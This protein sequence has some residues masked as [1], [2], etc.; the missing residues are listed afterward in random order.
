L[1]FRKVLTFDVGIT[2]HNSVFSK[3]CYQ[4]INYKMKVFNFYAGPAILPQEVIK[5]TADEIINFS[6][7]GLSLMEI[8]HRSK[9]FI[10][11][12][13]E[14]VY[15]VKELLQLSEDYEV[16]F[17]S[18]GASSQ[19][20]M[21]PMNLLDENGTAAYLDTGTWASKAIQEARLF[22]NV[23][24]VASSKDQKYSFIPKDYS[25]NKDYTYFHITSN[26]TIYGTQMHH[27]PDTSIPLAGDMS[28]DIFS[29]TFDAS[30]FGIIYAGAQKNM[31]PAGTTLV[32]IR[33]DLL[34]KV[35]RNIPSML[36]YENHISNGSMYN[37]PPV[38]PVYVSMLTMRWIKAQ[39]GVSS[40]E[41]QN[42]GKA[43]LLYNE[44]DHNGLFFSPVNHED[45]SNMNVC[46]LLKNN[47]LEKE[48][49]EICKNEHLVGLEGHRSVGGFRASIYNAM[50]KD[51]VQK[52][53]DIMKE[54]E[55]TKG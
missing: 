31:G 17:L 54:F 33:K 44:I 11:V 49:K 30:K 51:G 6:G 10:S 13:D 35:K 41:T 26:N 12:M 9:D 2:I 15:L 42:A 32:V 21:V 28:S 18:G 29:R 16:L 5:Q 27:F 3:K 43:A 36:N 50:D 20:F 52:L 48:F 24:V 53:V 14:A 4:S 7:S 8:S 55:R 45:R 47:D 23:D 25:L 34:G 39:G 37:T 46:F 1:L 40:M 38:L 22:G 19:F